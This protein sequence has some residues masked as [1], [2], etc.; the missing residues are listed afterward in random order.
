MKINDDKCVICGGYCG[1][2]RH[3]CN[4]CM[5][6]V[7]ALV[8]D[9]RFAEDVLK[10]SE[11]F[12]CSECGIRLTKCLRLVTDRDGEEEVFAYNYKFC[13]NCGRKIR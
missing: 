12:L 10:G 1:E 8:A 7:E 4:P 11:D 2:G 6:A 9:S 5:E 3:V 13:P